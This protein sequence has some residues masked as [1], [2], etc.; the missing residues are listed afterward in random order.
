MS[1]LVILVGAFGVGFLLGDALRAH[2]SRRRRRKYMR[3]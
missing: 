1:G 3:L 2:K